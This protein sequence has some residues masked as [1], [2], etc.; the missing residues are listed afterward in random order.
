MARLF[1]SIPFEELPEQNKKFVRTLAQSANISELIKERTLVLTLLGSKGAKPEWNDRRNSQGHISIP[2]SKK[3]VRVAS[4]D[5]A[6]SKRWTKT[7]QMK[8]VKNHERRY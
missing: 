2:Y 7:I 6:D 8:E 5:V 1:A 4:V 3:N